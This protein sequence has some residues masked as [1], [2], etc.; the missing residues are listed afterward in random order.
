MEIKKGEEYEVEIIDNGIDGQ[1]IAKINN[2]TIFVPQTTK[3]EKAKIL[4]LKVNK[5]YAFAKTLE[6]LEKSPNRVIEDCKTYKRCGGCS[7]R[8][9]D[10]EATLEIKE[11][12]VK[13]CLKKAT[14][15]KY[16]SK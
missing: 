3:G 16:K 12:M 8:F 11:N 15:R 10:Y 7:L 4:I 14:R 9:L 13:N 6:I 5:N 1:G 2:F